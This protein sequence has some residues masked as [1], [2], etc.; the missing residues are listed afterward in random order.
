L[1]HAERNKVLVPLEFV[2][3]TNAKEIVKAE[4][5]KLKRVAEVVADVHEALKDVDPSS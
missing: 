4:K 3:K 2:E 5:R 1:R